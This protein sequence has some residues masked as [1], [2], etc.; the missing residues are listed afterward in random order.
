MT[1][2]PKDVRSEETLI[3]AWGYAATVE[4]MKTERLLLN[5][6]ETFMFAKANGRNAAKNGRPKFNVPTWFSAS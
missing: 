5:E 4:K 2:A 3:S 6:E 1:L